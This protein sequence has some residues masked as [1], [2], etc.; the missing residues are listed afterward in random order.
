MRCLYHRDGDRGSRQGEWWIMWAGRGHCHWA[1]LQVGTVV[2]AAPEGAVVDGQ[3]WAWVRGEPEIPGPV[4]ATEDFTRRPT[5]RLPVKQ[6]MAMLGSISQ[7][8]RSGLQ[9]SPLR[10]MEMIR[11]YT[12]SNLGTGAWR[13]PGRRGDAFGGGVPIETLR[14]IERPMLATDGSWRP[15]VRSR[16]RRRGVS[17]S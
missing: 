17:G 11:S 7:S 4:G 16:R 2:S 1:L 9:L 3:A 14:P 8:S 6:M 13:R 5:W 12:A 15:D 10:D